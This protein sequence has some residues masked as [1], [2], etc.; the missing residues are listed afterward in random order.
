M[1]L[2]IIY[3]DV[4][5][6]LEKPGWFNDSYSIK[7]IEKASDYFKKKFLEFD[8]NNDIITWN[9]RNIIQIIV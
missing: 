5:S 7:Y 2:F 9:L 6:N 3:S 4:F 8:V 1:L